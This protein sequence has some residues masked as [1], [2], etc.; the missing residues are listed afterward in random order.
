MTWHNGDGPGGV[1]STDRGLTHLLDLGE[2]GLAVKATQ[3][4]SVSD[5]DNRGKLTRGMCMRHYRNWLDHTPPEDRGPAPRFARTFD[6][7]VD[8]SGDCWVWTGPANPKGYGYWSARGERGL[9][10]RLALA[11]VTPPSDPSL[12]AC[13]HCDNPPCVNPSHLYWGTPA[14]NAADAVERN[15]TANANKLKTH[16]KRGHELSGS[17][18]Q[19]LGAARARQCR[20]CGNERSRQ[21]MAERR[22]R[23]SADERDR[24][25]ARRRK[26]AA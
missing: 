16:C 21:A 15:R 8:R 17:N 1:G 7:F 5:C 10:H 12:F 22:A 3:A 9:A 26:G 14:D 6:D 2:R 24:Y 20:T 19:I 18:L 4:C 11:R 13:H 23:M 25:N